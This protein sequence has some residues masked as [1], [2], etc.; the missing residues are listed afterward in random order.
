MC[1]YTYLLVYMCYDD[2]RNFQRVTGTR[3][4][5]YLQV[6]LGYARYKYIIIRYNWV[7]I[8]ED[9]GKHGTKWIAM[10]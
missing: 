3:L 4:G 7:K 1:V 6:T 5:G 10:E 8:A 9:Q 2:H